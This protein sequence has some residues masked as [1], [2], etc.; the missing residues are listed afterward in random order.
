MKNGRK[1]VRLKKQAVQ[2]PVLPRD[3]A[4]NRSRKESEQRS[5][6]AKKKNRNDIMRRVKSQS[7]RKTKTDPG[8]HV[9]KAAMKRA[10]KRKLDKRR[11][12]RNRIAVVC[13][14][15][16]LVAIMSVQIT[17]L[18]ARNE[19]YLAKEEQLKKELKSEQNRTSALQDEQ[20]YINSDEYKEDI[21]RSRLSMAYDNEIIFREK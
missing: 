3:R 18:N 12:R 5:M 20:K 14:V 19:S 16:V 2:E 15:G 10:A 8:K 9:S 6:G 17:H 4:G 7:T 21:A 1:Y 11:S 13:M